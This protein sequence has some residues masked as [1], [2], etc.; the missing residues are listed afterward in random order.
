MH[1]I[2]VASSQLTILYTIY[3]KRGQKAMDAAGILPAFQGVAIHDHWFA[4]FAYSQL[5]H[6]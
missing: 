4:Y 2:H 3:A 5:K 1:W 6:G